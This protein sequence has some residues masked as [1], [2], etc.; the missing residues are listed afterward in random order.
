MREKWIDIAKGIGI[1]LMV[2]GHA[3]APTT[4]KI[5]IYGFHMPLF[6]IIAGYTFNRNKWIAKGFVPLIISRTKTYLIPYACFLIV[7]LILWGALVRIT[8]GGTQFVKWIL[9]GIYSHDELM[10]NCAPIWFLTCLFVTYIFFWVLIKKSIKARIF[11][12]TMYLVVLFGI[13]RIEKFYGITQLPWHIDVGLIAAVFMLIG[14][15]MK[16]YSI[17]EQVKQW[18]ILVCLLVGTAIVLKNGRIN[19]VQNQYQNIGLFIVGAVLLTIVVLYIS[20]RVSNTSIHCVEY[21]LEL[22]GKNTLIFI[23]FNYLINAFVRQG[24]KVVGIQ[25]QM[26]YC[27]FDSI[28]VIMGCLFLSVLWNKIKFRLIK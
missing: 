18:H 28:V 24:V 16:E 11:Y 3:N 13:C 8:G 14:F 22:C 5:W 26:F 9:A 7:N 6:F 17:L 25:S 10:P 21:F 19:M 1:I 12:S 4:L 2:I 15:E 27:I 23:G 20:R